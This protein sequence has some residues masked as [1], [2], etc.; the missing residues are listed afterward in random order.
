LEQQTH[1]ADQ[2]PLSDEEMLLLIREIKR[3]KSPALIGLY[4]AT[5]RLVFGLIIRILGERASAE[6]AL[7][8]I[9][10]KIW[11]QSAVYDAAM[12]PVEWLMNEAHRVAVA[13]MHWTKRER[14]QPDSPRETAKSP[15]TVSPERQTAA[16]EALRTLDPIQRELLDRAY[17]HGLSCNEMA[18]QIGKPAGAIRAQIRSG[19]NKLGESCLQQTAERD[20]GMQ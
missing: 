6:E 16:R 3:G 2:N 18:A 13:R 5:N 11:N 17:F 7:L 14:I 9:Y 1:A 15:A 12:S 10:T 19:L 4:D 8:D 20:G